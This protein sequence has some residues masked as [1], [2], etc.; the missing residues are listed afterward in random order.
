[1]FFWISN[2][3]DLYGQFDYWT[4]IITICLFF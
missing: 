4:F 3:I 1:M 2:L